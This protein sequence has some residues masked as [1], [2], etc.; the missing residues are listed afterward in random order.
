[1]KISNTFKIT[2]WILLLIILVSILGFRIQDIINGNA[3]PFDIFLFIIFI[4]LC[5]AVARKQK[6]TE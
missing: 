5:E 6:T 1:M 3:K 4:A 2:W